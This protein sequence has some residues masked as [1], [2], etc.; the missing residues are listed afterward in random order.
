MSRDLPFFVAR[1]ASRGFSVENSESILLYY[2][3]TW[4]DF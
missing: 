1:L 2:I 4:S 3:I